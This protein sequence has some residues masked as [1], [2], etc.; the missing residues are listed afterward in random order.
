M[1]KSSRLKCDTCGAVF[2]SRSGKS[3]EGTT[4]P[5]CG[6]RLDPLD[7]GLFEL[8]LEGE[9]EV[10]PA[11]LVEG[12]K[13]RYRIIEE[14]GRGGMGV[15]YRAEQLGVNREVA[16]K[17]LIAG[18]VADEDT[19]RRFVRESKSAGSL[20]HPN[21]VAVHDAGIVNNI[22]YFSMDFVDGKSLA[23]V[24]VT[25]EVDIIQALQLTVKLARALQVAH[26]NG[27]IHRDLKP[28]NVIIDD[29]GEPHITDF[30]LA[31]DMS[32]KSMLS[33]SG[34]LIGTP[35]Y[36]SPES[37]SGHVHRVD[38]R[39][40][41]YSL[42]TILY[43]MLTHSQPFKGKT[44]YETISRVVNIE[45]PPPRDFNHNLGPDLDAIVMKALNKNVQQRYQS[46]TEFADDIEH[47]LRGEPVTARPYRKIDKWLRKL[48]HRAH[49]VAAGVG[50]FLLIA[51][52]TVLV[53]VHRSHLEVMARRLADE[54][55][56]IRKTA[57]EML[58]KE[59]ATGR[60]SDR[61]DRSD[62]MKL[63]VRAARDD[64][65]ADIRLLAVKGIGQY[66]LTEAAAG[67][68]PVLESDGSVKVRAEAALEAAFAIFTSKF[69]SLI[70][71]SLP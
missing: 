37:A 44:V 17:V 40:D 63:V 27:V 68:G 22:H 34:T 42:A 57:L 23:D 59:L 18:D 10:A 61:D 35:M 41:V 20:K 47:Y 3:G 51:V 1:A 48:R 11:S 30:G 28:A 16:L 69:Q 33:V 15:V 67:L 14:V 12:L 39:S 26:E 19:V 24:M 52:L 5:K 71:S 54:Q 43:E 50:A 32:S 65:D 66:R 46:M 58:L 25:Q 29:S 55:P 21:I 9:G 7:A 53:L 13:E 2:R 31:R 60:I 45:P 38:A 64:P 70:M 36:T 49:Y 62:A 6:G 8:K 4:C 56:G